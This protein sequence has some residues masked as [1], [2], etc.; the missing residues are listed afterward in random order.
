MSVKPGDLAIVICQDSL[1]YG[2]IVEV[3]EQAPDCE[4]LLPD[5]L[6]S[7]SPGGALAFLCKSI[8]GALPIPATGEVPKRGCY[9]VFYPTNLRPLPGDETPESETRRDEVAA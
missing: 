6:W 1:W 7:E 8:G 3:I 9:G 2:Q 4:F 5:G